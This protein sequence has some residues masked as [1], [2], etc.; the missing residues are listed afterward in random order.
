MP[1]KNAEK[2]GGS[3]TPAARPTPKGGKK[4]KP[5]RL[6]QRQREALE[7]IRRAA[8]DG[9]DELLTTIDK[10]TFRALLRK[11]VIELPK[12]QQPAVKGTVSRESLRKALLAVEKERSKTEAVSN[13]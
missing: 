13:G 7:I 8:T 2:S 3:G 1:V 10:D 12:I 11:K 6:T 5:V 9:D 4:V